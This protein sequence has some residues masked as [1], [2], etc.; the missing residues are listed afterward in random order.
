MS[1]LL[2]NDILNRYAELLRTASE[3]KLEADL[4]LAKLQLAVSYKQ[5]DQQLAPLLTSKEVA[6]LLG[7]TAT[8]VRLLV[9][10]GTLVP[11]VMGRRGISGGHRFER[12]VV[13]RLMLGLV[14]S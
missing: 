1:S 4:E 7:I 2:A 3:A 9:A 8:R 12:R 11:A 6:R 13:E 10:R 14:L 5:A